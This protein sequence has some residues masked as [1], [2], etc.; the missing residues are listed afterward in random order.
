[1]EQHHGGKSSTMPDDRV[2]RILEALGEPEQRAGALRAALGTAGLRED[3]PRF[4]AALAKIGHEQ[5]QEAELAELLRSHAVVERA[6]RGELVIPEW[7]RFATELRDIFDK[8][9]PFDGGKVATYI[10]QLARV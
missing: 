4:A 7:P 1:M 3:D 8:T 10:P 5:H 9:R 2:R 6:L